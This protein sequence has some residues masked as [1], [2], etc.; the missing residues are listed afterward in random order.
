MIKLQNH[1]KSLS[2]ETRAAQRQQASEG[3]LVERFWSN[4]GLISHFLDP[5]RNTKSHPRSG[6]MAPPV[7]RDSPRPSEQP[8]LRSAELRDTSVSQSGGAAAGTASSSSGSS[9][10]RPTPS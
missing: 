2:K 6:P 4:G 10:D 9:R 8:P 3:T 5:E 7:G 1:F